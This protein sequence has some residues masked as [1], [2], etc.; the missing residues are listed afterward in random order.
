MFL[1]CPFH[2]DDT[3]CALLPE[4]K[5]PS[6]PTSILRI[7]ISAV[8][9]QSQNSIYIQWL[10][11]S[12]LPEWSAN[13]QSS[14]SYPPIPGEAFQGVEATGN[15]ALKTGDNSLR[16]HPQSTEKEKRI[17]PATVHL[18]SSENNI[19][20]CILGSPFVIFFVIFFGTVFNW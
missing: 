9:P 10:L 5:A 13:F 11:H 1:F 4:V 14:T 2:S 17:V 12:L 3:F 16:K 7:Y 15:M 18:F 6:L 20:S 8:L 19:F